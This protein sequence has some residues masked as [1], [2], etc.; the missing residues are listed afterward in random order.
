MKPIEKWLKHRKRDKNEVVGIDSKRRFWTALLA[1]I[2]F[3]ILFYTLLSSLQPV[4]YDL[5]IGQ[6]APEDIH[7]P[8]LIVDE[9]QTRE[10][11]QD[12]VDRVEFVYRLDAGIYPEV[13]KDIDLFFETLYD[14]RSD[15]EASEEAMTEEDMA[16]ALEDNVLGIHRLQ[17][18]V[19]LNQPVER[20]ENLQNYL[21]EITAQRMNN[22]IK[23]ADLQQEKSQIRE[24]MSTLTEFDED[25]R[26][27]AATIIN[28]SLRP[29]EFLDVEATDEAKLAAEESVETVVIRRGD[30]LIRQGERVT[31]D[32]LTIM[33][34]L[35][36][37]EEAYQPNFALYAGIAL[38]ILLAMA[39]VI[40]YLY[41]FQR[42]LLTQLDKLLLLSIIIVIIVAM[43]RPLSLISPYLVPVAVGAML[44]SMLMDPRLAIIANVIITLFVGMITGNNILVL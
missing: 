43:A 3:S 38:T 1:V 4:R 22:G 44:L 7:S 27:T 23:V 17:L 31:A 10:L 42:S 11:R 34:E 25:L 33:R 24:Y 39:L 5:R 14:V 18:A 13:K 29:N 32:R 35:G 20:L 15:A 8:K 2:T 9:Y 16:L 21:H 19:L 30:I 36:L 37:L 40:G 12:A 6:L 28:A 41:E 26:E